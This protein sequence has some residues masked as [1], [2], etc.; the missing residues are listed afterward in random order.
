MKKRLLA[1]LL[2]VVMIAS[3]IVLPAG[4]ESV[5]F[6]STP[7]TTC[8]HCGADWDSIEWKEFGY[9]AEAALEGTG[10]LTGHYYVAD[11]QKVKSAYTFGSHEG[12]TED[13][14]VDVC[15]D[16]QGCTIEASKADTRVLFV[17]NYSRLSI[18]DSVGGG[19]VIGTG[20][21]GSGG[22]IY[23]AKNSRVDLYNGKLVNAQTDRTKN[24]GVVFVNTVQIAELLVK[25]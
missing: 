13:L 24:G 22:T 23:Q 19:Q 20:K 18:I 1:L 8:P 4:A 25:E 16:L 11:D 3:M 21:T 15:V 2:V 12:Q 9:S 5:D 14:A 7:K 10:I 6:G 17:Y